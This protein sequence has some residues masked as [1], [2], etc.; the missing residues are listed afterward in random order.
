MPVGALWIN[1]ESFQR[2][3]SPVSL[4]AHRNP[5]VELS[6]HV[7]PSKVATVFSGAPGFVA[8]SMILSPRKARKEPCFVKPYPVKRLS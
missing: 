2:A 5:L 6:A 8:M 3:M 7:T 4:A 1:T